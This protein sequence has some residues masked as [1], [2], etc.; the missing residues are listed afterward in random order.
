MALLT[1]PNLLSAL[2][3]PLAGL[4]A[5]A[6]LAGRPAVA[7]LAFTVAA[8]SDLADGRIARRRGL[9]S[10]FGGLLDH[11]ADALYVTVVLAAFAVR[12]DLNPLLPVLVPLAFMQYV[13]D[14]R[15]LAGQALRSS[16]LGRYNGIAY[17]VLAGTLVGTDLLALP[18]VATLA[19]LAGWVLVA[20]T[21]LSMLD[22]LLAL[23]R[24]RRPG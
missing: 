20:S 15:A 14:S 12:G 18:P 11:S 2:R 17:Y 1:A 21:G 16:L 24:L 4:T 7:A 6:V 5:W 8:L 23:L 10:V 13:L 19:A 9:V 3:I 22:R